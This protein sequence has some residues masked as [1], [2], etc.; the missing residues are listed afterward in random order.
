MLHWLLF[1]TISTLLYA[2]TYASQKKI[3]RAPDV[4]ISVKVV[5][6][7]DTV[8]YSTVFWNIKMLVAA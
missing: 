5:H 1:K 4:A 3:S 2:Q 8:Q 6:K 7:D